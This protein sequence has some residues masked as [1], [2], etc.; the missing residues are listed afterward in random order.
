MEALQVTRPEIVQA[1]RR[2]GLEA[3]DTVLVH[4]SL[5]AIGNV[6]GGADTVIDALLEVLTPAGTLVMPAFNWTR[7][8]DPEAL[9]VVGVIPETFRKRAGVVRGFHPTHPV[10]ALGAHAAELLKDHL[11]SP[12]PC[13]RD[14]P[15]GRL[16]AAGGKVLLLGV[17]NDRSTT[18]HTLEDYAD[19]PYLREM[20]ASYTDTAGELRSVHLKRVPGPHRDFIG[21][22][23]LFRR[24]GVEVIGKVGNAVA[25]LISAQKMHDVVMEAFRD[26]PALVLCDNP[27]CEACMAQRRSIRLARLREESF[28]LSALASSVSPYAEEIAAEL[29]RAGIS[30]LVL[31]R[32]YGQPVWSV[33]ETR[34]RRAASL[35]S[36]EGVKIG[37]VYCPPDPLA[38]DQHLG[39]VE[40]LGAKTAVVPFP[41]DLAPF[42]AAAAGRGLQVIFENTSFPS[43]VCA[44]LMREAGAGEALAFNPAAFALGGERPF[45]DIVNHGPFRRQI[46]MLLLTDATFGG[47]HTLPARG[48]GEVKEVLSV[49]RCRSFAGR[50]VV[51]TGPGGPDFRRLVE[52]FWTLMETS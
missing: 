25:R 12:T 44:R 34:L 9:S 50:V 2:V 3:G 16:I 10:S 31:D 26:D 13:G 36:E 49:L 11:Q 38:F 4:S 33:P 43:G 8:Y 19:A 41:P 37:A 40:A 46:A 51:A 35:L 5:S 21:L 22:H 6:P 15:F 42:L 1:L 45:L 48:N 28:T 29:S 18:M 47:E 14:T 23:P 17:D 32:I 27:S 52:G 39:L 7:P 20:D 30:D 24:C